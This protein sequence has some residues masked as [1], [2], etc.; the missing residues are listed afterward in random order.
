MRHRKSAL[1]ARALAW[2]AVA[3]V[4]LV[5]STPGG[6]CQAAAPPSAGQPQKPAAPTP[7]EQELDRLGQEGGQAYSRGD[8]AAAE[9]AYQ[10]GLGKA[11]ELGDK[12]RISRF[13]NSL[14]NVYFRLGQF[15]RA[16]DYHTRALALFE[17]G[18]RPSALGYKQA[19]AIC[20]NNLGLVYDDLGQFDKALDY[21]TRAL[22]LFEA[23]GNKQ[24]GAICLNNLGSV[25]L[26]LGQFDKALDYHNR[27]LAI[28]EAIGNK[29]DIAGSFNNLGNVY[30]SLGQYEKA[31]D[32][33]TRALALKEAIGNKQDIANS[34]N[35][36][37]R[38]Y[39]RLGQ[40]DKAEDAFAQALRNFEDLSTQVGD[41]A[42]LGALQDTLPRFY[43]AYA[44]LLVR[45]HRPA[46]PS[47]SS[48]EGEA[49]AWP[50]R[51]RSTARTSPPSS[52]GRRPNSSRAA[53]PT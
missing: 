42:E 9:K 39:A 2:L 6:F 20:L 5:V 33:Y 31:L 46:S 21:Y 25:Y 35:N 48:S 52:H 27:A 51:P 47:H 44:A 19:S 13:L 30:G 26:N 18:P 49:P 11:Q 17:A 7:Q 12:T 29:Q 4:C 38:T 10:A 28:E 8:Y 43:A 40:P 3:S 45:R 24:A 23:L 16:L 32:Y 22:T 41:P 50:G 53:P 1:I 36:L 34:L 37:G 14:G 15:D